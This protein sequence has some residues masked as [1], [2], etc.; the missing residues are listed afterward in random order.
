[1]DAGFLLH[2]LGLMIRTPRVGT[3]GVGVVGTGVISLIG[4]GIARIGVGVGMMSPMKIAGTIPGN[5][6]VG[7]VGAM[8]HGLIERRLDQSDKCDASKAIGS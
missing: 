7:T 3:V 1:M 5:G 2:G 8:M 4:I 6:I